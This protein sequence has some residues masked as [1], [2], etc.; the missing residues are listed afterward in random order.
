MVASVSSPAPSLR[1]TLVRGEGVHVWD[2]DGRRYLDAISGSFSVQ[3]GYGRADLARALTEA[4]SRLAYARPS[5]FESEESEAYAEE[6]L[7]AAGPPY[8]RAIFTTSGS[9]AVDAALKAAYRYQSARGHPGRTGVAHLRGHFHG[10]TL[11]ALRVT[12]VRA[13]RA[14]YELLL[15]GA[16]PPIDPE[17]GPLEEA[18]GDSG[19]L[20]AETI[21]AA[22]LG[23]PV[24][25]PGFLAEIRRACDARDALWIADEVLTGFGR[26]G[27]LFAWKRLTERGED[28]GAR[29]DIIAFGK[30]A[31]GGY[32]PIG[33][34]LFA[35]RVA[36]VLDSAPGGAF[37]HAQT[38]GGH[39]I[40]CAVGRHVL[41]VM[42]EEN[43]ES[44]VREKEKALREALSALSAHPHVLDVRGLGFL[45]GVLLRKDRRT[46][47]PF[48]RELRI[49]ERVE[50]ACRDRGLLV[51]SGSGS[52]DGNLGDHLLVGP[53][54]V[55]DTH[56]FPQIA[57]GIRESLDA[58][59]RDTSPP[60][61]SRG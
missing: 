56:H 10:A 4:A 9:E 59:M 36:S 24:P 39:A 30:G 45:W 21:P 34:V 6:I 47:E 51:F 35:E 58:V 12:D 11:G 33:G 32:A 60:G 61:P 55:S 22:G 49:A 48:P 40:A 23:A 42:R 13:R 52:H 44:R 1:P 27:S 19:A 14:P 53:P 20:L 18:M 31:G 43:I 25:R 57:I 54:L 28:R 5:R 50:A 26:V 29:P 46:G 7:L 8:T 16:P 17:A 3:L 15:G 37:S 41:A 2:R 38:Y